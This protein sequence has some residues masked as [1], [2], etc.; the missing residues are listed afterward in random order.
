MSAT[1]A[2]GAEEQSTVKKPTVAIQQQERLRTRVSPRRSTY[3]QRAVSTGGA[4]LS[5]EAGSRA[6]TRRDRRGL[7][8]EPAGPGCSNVR[9]R[10]RLRAAHS[11]SHTL[12]P[13]VGG[14][15]RR[16]HAL[17]EVCGGLADW[18]ALPACITGPVDEE[19]LPGNEYL[20]TGNRVLGSRITD[21]GA[22][23]VDRW[24]APDAPR[25]ASRSRCREPRRIEA[26]LPPDNPLG[27]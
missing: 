16:S 17:N 23:E 15:R 27:S 21:H 5:T 12:S 2:I 9:E 10:A 24:R 14:A 1:G 26:M 3:Q 25:A 22:A 4:S 8:S 11:P 6:R 18:K 7:R 19:L 20:A 13:S